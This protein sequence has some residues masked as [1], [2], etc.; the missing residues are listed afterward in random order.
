MSRGQNAAFRGRRASRRSGPARRDRADAARGRRRGK[1]WQALWD[2]WSPFRT[3]GRHP[4]AD[5]SRK[6]S[7]A[8]GS[9]SPTPDCRS[10]SD[11]R[12]VL[13]ARRRGAI[14]TTQQIEASVGAYRPSYTDNLRRPKRRPRRCPPAS[15]D[16][17]RRLRWCLGL[18]MFGLGRSRRTRVRADAAR[19]WS[20]G[21]G[22]ETVRHISP[23]RRPIF[24][25]SK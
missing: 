18:G 2:R 12:V 5:R 1:T 3:L 8:S 24:S 10:A 9:W 15:C 23:C 22:A 25:T 14:A 4:G 19:C 16:P 20:S 13:P 21:E 7:S 17:S 11:G 6:M